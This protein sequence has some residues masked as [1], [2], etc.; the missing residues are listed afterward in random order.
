MN[1]YRIAA[2]EA[3]NVV[4]GKAAAFVQPVR[5]DGDHPPAGKI[6]ILPSTQLQSVRQGLVQE[7]TACR[8]PQGS[9][10][11]PQ[12][13]RICSEV[14]HQTA[15]VAE[16][17][18][19]SSVV[20]SELV[21]PGVNGVL[22]LGELGGPEGSGNVDEEDRCDPFAAG[23]EGFDGNHFGGVLAQGGRNLIFPQAV[24]PRSVQVNPDPGRP[25]IH[26]PHRVQSE[27]LHGLGICGAQEEADSDNRNSLHPRSPISRHRLDRLPLFAGQLKL[28]SQT[29]RTGRLYSLSASGA[30]V[31]IVSCRIGP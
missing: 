5:E 11:S 26:L 8:R 16:G 10:S 3:E 14:H 2:Q 27:S 13:V 20:G 18:D 9:Q 6:R 7:S 28:C 29:P 25:V 12:R 21:D 4:E 31:L 1:R 19:R 23:L 22:N 30:P 17:D 24:R 15:L